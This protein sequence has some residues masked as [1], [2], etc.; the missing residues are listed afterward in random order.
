MFIAIKINKMSENN[1][2]IVTV[3]VTLSFVFSSFMFV[4]AHTLQRSADDLVK[5]GVTH[6]TDEQKSKECVDQGGKVITNDFGYSRC[7]YNK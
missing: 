4:Y 7:D 2:T 6:K 3:G 1:K 5:I